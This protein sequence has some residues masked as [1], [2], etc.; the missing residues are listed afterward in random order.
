ME[1]SIVHA[2][3]VKTL[4][5]L[6][7]SR[8]LS[9]QDLLDACQLSEQLLLNDSTTVPFTSYIDLANAIMLAMDDE[10]CGMLPTPIKPGSFALLCQSC[11]DC[12]TLEHF[13]RRRI[14]FLGLLSD[15]I[16]LS[17]SVDRNTA[18]Y[19]LRVIEGRV[20]LNRHIVVIILALAYRVGSWSIRER[21][22][23]TNV[24]LAGESC[25]QDRDYE[26]LFDHSV[27]YDCNKNQLQFPA[28]YLQRPVLQ[29]ADSMQ[30][31][32]KAPAFYLMSDFGDHQ[33]FAAKVR[34]FVRSNCI[35]GPPAIEA[36]AAFFNISVATLRRRLQGFDT[37]YQLV[38]DEVRRDI[39]LTVLASD[40]NVK[41]AAYASGFSDPATFSRAFKRWTGTTPRAYLS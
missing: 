26:F 11:L 21:I 8:G 14:K 34:A 22:P 19:E 20:P 15:E 10:S 13:L 24:S 31:F 12:K 4:L 39:A 7:D 23:L 16:E 3:H 40:K 28:E 38:K 25:E 41:A 9:R 5:S 27:R 1:I 18:T 36:A 30:E 33:S 17:L 2:H 37:S 6:A 32:L 29:D 35:S